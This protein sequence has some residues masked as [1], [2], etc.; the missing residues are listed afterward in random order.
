MWGYDANWG[1]F[2]PFARVQAQQLLPKPH[3]LTWEEAGSCGVCLFTAY[4]ML[5]TRARIQVGENVLIWGAAGGMGHF[6]IQLCQ[7]CGAKPIAVVSS[8]EKAKFCQELGCQWTINHSHFDLCATEGRREFRQEIRRLTGGQDPDI[9]FEHVG[10]ET[11]PT[12]VYVCKRFGRV[13]TSGA[14][15]GYDVQ[16]DVRYLWTQHK[17]IIGSHHANAHDA[18][19]ANLLLMEGKIR[20]VIHQLFPF[21]RIPE[22]TTLLGRNEHMGKIT[23]LV[24]AE[25][26]GLGVKE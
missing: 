13:V 20:P 8:D 22:A 15:T 10:K 19:R 11:F 14:T 18:E 4:R 24:Q 5:V 23:A 26:A 7:V 2:A 1:S 9:V 16:F 17:S 12:S 3:C 6:A 21:E 25:T